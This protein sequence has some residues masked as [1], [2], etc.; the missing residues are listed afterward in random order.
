MSRSG[1][2]LGLRTEVVFFVSTALFLLIVIASF[3]LLAYRNA[4]RDIETELV[5]GATELAST[6]AAR[7][8]AETQPSPERIRDLVPTAVAASVVRGEGSRSSGFGEPTVLDLT[9]LIDSERPLR[10]VG[11]G[12]STLG[13]GRVIAVAPFEHQGRPYHLQLELPA[14]RLVA[15]Q[16]ESRRLLMLN[17]AAL[18]GLTI[19]VLL[20]LRRL[21]APFES[22]LESAKRVEPTQGGDLDE[23]RFL[24]ETFD[25]ALD[26][27]AG[28]GEARTDE[29][30]VLRQTLAPSLSSGFMLLGPA[31]DV[32][33][34]NEL[35][36]QLLRLPDTA[37]GMPLEEL[38]PEE[39]AFTTA[40]AQV[41][42]GGSSIQ[43]R[44]CEIGTGEER[45]ILGV[46]A[47]PLRRDDGVLRGFIVLFVDLTEVKA[48]QR[49]AEISRSLRQI[50][51]VAAGVA[52]EMRNGLGTLK[53]YLALI[54]RDPE[55]EAVRDY[56]GEMRQESAHLERVVGD[57]LSFARPGSLRG[58]VVDLTKIV[59]RSVD[60][61]ALAA[62]RI[63]LTTP[64]G[65]VELTGDEQLLGRALRNLLQNACEAQAANDRDEPVVV[66]LE[67]VADT[68]SVVIE[69][70]GAGLPDDL[71][72]SIFQ[73]FVSGRPD[74]VG[75]GLT[76]AHRI[77]ELHGG[78]L[79]IEN[80]DS[81]GARVALNLPMVVGPQ[82]DD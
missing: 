70:S 8:S 18:A 50:G 21:L 25:R 65:A 22:L 62:T 28:R 77:A 64:D 4:L 3:N 44:E 9:E 41:V 10:A 23:S 58:S 73:P 7:L 35:G 29:I 1:R 72:D 51:E 26:A 68:A 32:L 76:L 49:S 55:G 59:R 11:F 82:A 34:I 20:F 43:R 16:T 69:D 30:D 67:A 33:S 61:P 38:I 71:V 31:G 24:I 45:S 75:L 15:R 36:R 6:A 53:G 52:H 79:T 19:L 40:V 56:L 17:A 81:G 66:R 74:G 60:D 14:D 57:F 80:R 27:L 13:G 46:G 54:E 47:H 12:P 39:K 5:A 78:E 48:R 2:R 63:E 37:L 42:R